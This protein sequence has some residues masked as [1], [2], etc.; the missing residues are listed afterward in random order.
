MIVEPRLDY[1]CAKR[2]PKEVDFVK[3]KNVSVGKL[4][5]DRLVSRC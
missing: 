2:V 4:K 5:L 3:K 1:T